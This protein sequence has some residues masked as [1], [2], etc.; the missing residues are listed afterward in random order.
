MWAWIW[1]F[2]LVSITTILPCLFQ[3]I[4][5]SKVWQL[6]HN[7]VANFTPTFI[8]LALQL[9]IW[10]WTPCT[11]DC[12]E[13]SFC[14]SRCTIAVCCCKAKGT[15]TSTQLVPQQPVPFPSS[16]LKWQEEFSSPAM[17][18]AHPALS[19][20]VPAPLAI[21]SPIFP[22]SKNM[23]KKKKRMFALLEI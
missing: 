17:L 19:P 1:L 5:I 2:W 22:L 11:T 15:V 8:N 6:K 14:L 4:N 20:S 16:Y 9:P 18:E 12:G 13:M 21:L 23:L 10:E 3:E 7:L